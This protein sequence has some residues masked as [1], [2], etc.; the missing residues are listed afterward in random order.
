M[1]SNG[2]QENIAYIKIMNLL[3]NRPLDINI[4][5]YSFCPMKCVFC[6]N[7]IY[8]RD[9]NLMSLKL[10][11]KI[12]REYCD[13][14]N[15]GAIGIGAMQSDF[16]SDPL[17]LKRI[18]ILKKYKRKLYV[19][20]TTPL[21]TCHKYTD[22]ELI[23]ILRVFDYLEISIE[24]HDEESYYKMTGVKGFHM[25]QEQLIRI[26]RLKIQKHIQCHLKLSFR[27]YNVK[28]LK[29]SDFYKTT[30][31]R[32]K[33]IEIKDSFFSWFGSIKKQDLVVG[34]KLILKNNLEKNQNCAVPY[35]TLAVQADGKV[36]GCGCIDWLEKY[37]VGDCKRQNLKEI[38][39]SK[40]AQAFR[41][42]F[43]R[44]KLPSICKECGLYVTTRDAFAKKELINYRPMDGIY[45]NINKF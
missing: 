32:Y 43:R 15:G 25:L 45:Y 17:L 23:E 10:F 4:E 26:E 35:A 39:K 11:E 13:L 19:Y 24:G 40:K 42:A 29:K 18:E 38:W 7:R 3:S 30:S 1:I 36:I 16:L 37:V 44:G 28:E 12:I 31:A 22:E 21:I 33:N 14:F 41:N 34:S 8:T 20:S 9:R 5:T 6:C 27:T 2:L